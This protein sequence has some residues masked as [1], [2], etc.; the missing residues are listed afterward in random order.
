MAE[1]EAVIGLEVHCQLNTNSKLFCTCP[2]NAEN[3]GPNESVCAICSAMPGVLPSINEQAVA[4]AAKLG[5][6]I[7][8]RV[9]LRSVFA[10][11]NYFYP[12]LPKAYQISQFDPPICEGGHL[13]ITADGTTKRIRINRIHMEED[14]GKTIHSPATNQSFVDLN[15]GGVPL[16]EIVSEPDLR[17]SEQAVAYL[18]TLRNIVLY[19]GISD[20]NMEEGNFR[21]DANVSIRPKG[22]EA[23]GTRTELK[24]LNSFRNVQRAIEYEIERHRD[25]LDDGKAVV[26]E[27]RLYDAAKNITLS[28]RSKE[29]AHDY[30]YCPDPD[31]L[32]VLV[33][34]EQVAAWSKA[35][36]ELPV[37]R[38]ARFESDFGL[39]EADADLLTSDRELADYFEQAVGHFNEPKRVA[40]LMLGELLRE[41]NQTGLTLKQAKI[42][43]ERLAALAK[44]I[45]EGVISSKI[46]HDIF[47]ALFQSGDDPSAY[48]E[49]HGLVQISDTSAIEEAVDR[50]IAANPTEAE[51]FKGGKT[52]LISFF[53]GQVMRETKGKANP[54]LVNELL[55]KKLG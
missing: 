4:D 39:P 25:V 40:N 26:Q 7:N 13:D 23:F 30:R 46:G 9:N 52:K 45:S 3:A 1:Y 51:A 36:P 55:Q 43:P 14:A 49:K 11:K 10:R 38:K 20:G 5:L 42:T 12:D 32:P 44:L 8:G 6:A 35:L 47:S 28:M 50:V 37:Q 17:S 31:L 34:E 2:A 21:C 22:A 16:L 24:N 29:E 19:L 15:R 48:V 53:V 33:T 54:G 27:T 41:L 18:K